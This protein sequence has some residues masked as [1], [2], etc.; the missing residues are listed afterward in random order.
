MIDLKVRVITGAHNWESVYSIYSPQPSHPHNYLIFR[1]LDESL[2][3]NYPRDKDS[4]CD[5]S[6][7]W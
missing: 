7:K 5:C 2:E 4:L 3:E 1:Q 6:L